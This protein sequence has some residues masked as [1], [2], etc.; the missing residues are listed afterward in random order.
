TKGSGTTSLVFT[1]TDGIMLDYSIA[2]GM[3][4]GSSNRFGN[5]DSALSTDRGD[6]GADHNQGSPNH[7]D[8]GNVLF[9]D[10]HVKGFPTSSWWTSTNC[11]Q[12]L[13]PAQP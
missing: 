3:M 13:N 7:D 9:L 11:N 8:Y 4:E 10:G 1:G 6:T 12:T 2:Y 5:A